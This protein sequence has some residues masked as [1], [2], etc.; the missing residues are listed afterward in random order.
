MF[1]SCGLSVAGRRRGMIQGDINTGYGVIGVK[2]WK[3][4]GGV[5]EA[6]VLTVGA[7]YMDNCF[8]GMG[9]QERHS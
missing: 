2:I 8:G 1:I 4:G 9:K 5:I 7:A 6:G 3:M